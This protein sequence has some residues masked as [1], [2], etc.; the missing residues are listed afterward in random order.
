MSNL[1]SKPLVICGPSGSGKSTLV[2]KLLQDFPNKF[3]YSVSHTTRKPRPGEVDGVH[4]HF[5]TLSTILNEIDEEKF[6]EY[7]MFS[8]NM[9]GTSKKT[10]E[11]VHSEGKICI[12]D[13]DVEGVK[14]VK[15][16]SLDPWYVF[17]KPPSLEELEVRLRKRST[18]HEENLVVRVQAATEEMKYAEDPKNFDLVVINDDLD[19]AYDQ[20]KEFVVTNVVLGN[21]EENNEPRKNAQS[22][23]E[24]SKKNQKN[25]LLETVY[26]DLANTCSKRFF[27]VKKIEIPTS[28][29]GWA[30]KFTKVAAS[31]GE[32][33]ISSY[34]KKEFGWCYHTRNARVKMKGLRIKH[35]YRY[36][37]QSKRTADWVVDIPKPLQLTP[38]AGP[39]A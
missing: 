11:L 25:I 3:G 38:V 22:R 20:L 10:V 32:K 5:V 30:V 17:I 29:Q 6:I 14:N 28:A 26:R 23:K 8:G 13:I 34:R 35:E 24:N 33:W 9:Y 1:A 39:E 18:E 36:E 21:S 12:L 27:G 7:T 16:T 4:Y 19:R 2:N 15:K 31:E 37:V